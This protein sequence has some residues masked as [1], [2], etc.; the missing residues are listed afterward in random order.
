M[1]SRI[2]FIA[3]AKIEDVAQNDPEYPKQWALENTGQAGGKPDADINAELMWNYQKGS[4]DIVVGIIDTGF[5]YTHPDLADNA[6]INPGEIPNN[7][8]D[9]DYNGFVDDMHGI[10][11]INNTGNPMD[12]NV[13]G[14]HVSGTIGAKGNNRLGVVGVAQN[15]QIAACKFLSSTGTGSISDAL[16]C[17][18]YFAA[19]KS[20]QNN[21]VNL[22]ATNNSWGGGGSSQAMLDAIRA[23]ERLGILFIAAAGNESSNNDSGSSYP[24]NYNV[25][26]VISVAATDNNDRLASFSNYGKKTVHVAAPGVKILS[27]ILNGKFGELSGTSMATPHVTG[28]VAI[29][30]SQFKGIDYINIKNLVMAGGQKTLAASTTTISGRRL[31]GADLNGIG[32]LSC[33]DQIVSARKQPAGS[34]YSINLGKSLFLAAMHVNCSSNAGPLT[35]YQNGDQSVVLYDDGQNGD[36]TAGDGIYSLNW[37][38]TVAGIYRLMFSDTDIVDVTVFQATESLSYQANDQIPS[39][40]ISIGG[41]RLGAGDETMHWVT[42]PFPILF[43]GDTKGFSELYVSSNGTISFTDRAQPRF[44]GTRYCPPRALPPWL[45]RFWGRF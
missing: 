1:L 2:T 31:R 35:L 42:S 18:D 9:D 38:P 10:N 40:Y 8:I 16:Q 29:I 17:M 24:A 33:G 45:R 13:H 4:R 28:L 26:N 22:I 32:S 5:D 25:S 34:N 20:R 43:A 15:I 41:Q 44:T 3:L 30:A 23:H 37:T 14:T 36:V 11:A 21:P 6:W 27:T 12:D 7:G 19:L 39:Q